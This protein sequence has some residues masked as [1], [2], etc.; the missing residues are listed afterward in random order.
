M[1]SFSLLDR[2]V[3]CESSLQAWR[4]CKMAV[5]VKEIDRHFFTLISYEKWMQ[6]VSFFQLNG[7]T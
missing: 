2:Y 5:L 4:I 6:L 7:R 1:Y 3:V